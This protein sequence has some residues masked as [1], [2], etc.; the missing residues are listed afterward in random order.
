VVYRC[1]CNLR[2]DLLVEIFEH[3]IVKLLYVVD[4]YMPKDAIAA[5][6]EFFY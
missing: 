5:D 1:E 4:Y 2:S 6:E 3:Y